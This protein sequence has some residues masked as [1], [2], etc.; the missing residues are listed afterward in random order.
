M[1]LKA[2]AVASSTS[3]GDNT[4]RKSYFKTFSVSDWETDS[5]AGTASLTIERSEHW[6]TEDHMQ[7]QVWYGTGT[8]MKTTAWCV[9]ETNIQI[10]DNRAV[11]L[12]VP[13][14]TGYAGGVLISG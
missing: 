4:S 2:E 10:N 11:I 9:M 7:V 14:R 3:G 12:T 8:A 6:I 13:S 5:A 1:I